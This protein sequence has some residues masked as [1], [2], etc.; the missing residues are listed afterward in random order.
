MP[1]YNS[2]RRGTAR[3][4]PKLIVFFCVLFVCKCVLYCCHRLST[5]L[6][7][8]NISIYISIYDYSQQYKNMGWRYYIARLVS[9]QCFLTTEVTVK[10]KAVPVQAWRVPGGWDSQISR[11]SAH[12]GGNVVRPMHRPPLSHRVY[13]SEIIVSVCYLPSIS[14]R[15]YALPCCSKTSRNKLKVLVAVLF[16]FARNFMFTRSLVFLLSISMAS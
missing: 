3:T 4:L 16:S 2:Q 14:V 10:G 8:T 12:E 1:G 7:L 5:Q 9:K 13:S 6:Q 15:S 11:H